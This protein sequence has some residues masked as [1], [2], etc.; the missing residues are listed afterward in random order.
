MWITSVVAD[1]RHAV[2]TIARMPVLATII[3]VSLG[4]GIGINTVVFSWMQAR[5][6]HPLP[7][8]P[9]SASFVLVE[10]RNTDNG[11]YLGTSWPEYRDL[12]ERLR[13]FPDL[14]AFRMVPLYVGESGSVDRAY[15]LLVSDNY[16]S[17]LRLQPSLGRFFRPDEVSRAGGE[18]V[19]V[20]SYGLWQARLGGATE[21]IGRPLRV[22]SRDVEIVGVA[23]R[24]FQGTVLGLNFDVWLPAT[25]APVVLRGSRELEDRSV[26]GYSAMGR[27]RPDSTRGHAQSELDAAMSELARVHPRTNAAVKG[28]ALSF[29]QSP[30]GP[31]RLLTTALAILQSVMLLLLLAVCGN[32]ATLVLARASARQREIGVRLALGASPWRIATLLLTENLLLGVLGAALGALLAVW[33]TQGLL[34]LP[35]SGLP[36]RFQTRVDGLGLAVAMILGILCGLTSGGAPALHLAR[37]DPQTALRSGAKPAGSRRLRH[38][39]MGVQAGLAVLVLVAAGLFLR[40]FLETRD[41]DPGFRRGRV[42]L[43]AYDLTGRNTDERARRAFA[44]KLLDRLHTLPSVEAAALATSVPLDIHGL[45]SRAFTVD[46]HTRTDGDSDRALA[47]TVTRGYFGVMGIPLR[48]GADFAELADVAAPPQVIVNEEFVRR[49]LDRLEPL[50][51]RLQARG[52]SYAIAGV[53]RDSLYNAFG[54]PPT[55]IVYF[56][57]RDGPTVSVEIHLRTRS[58]AATAAAHDVRRIVGEL[59]PD[60]PV[61][62]V[63]TLADHVETNLVFRRVPARM[64]AVLGPLILGLAAIGIYAVVAYSVSRRTMEIGVRVALGATTRRVVWHFVAEHLGVV[65]V[66]ALGGWLL[67]FVV[68][69]NVLGG[70]IDAPVFAGVPVLLLLVAALASWLPARH[71]A[72]VNPIDALRQE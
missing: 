64:F 26:R 1:V 12:R 52:R 57:Y 47:N 67:A 20:I 11:M 37:L 39:L 38:T 51:R 58:A 18:P 53:V 24:E 36:I 49:Y 44:G 71:A 6:L 17:A 60:L 22:N 5:L 28:E 61:F 69:L 35:L 50:G 14:L 68:V 30:R 54:E 62:N 56:S 34:A 32:T 25:L 72:R 16:F 3:V 31:Q 19:A 9:G 21:A 29:R 33:G 70:S 15:G 59:D 66:G 63:R 10:P 65:S 7:G 23:P 27:L 41:I 2:R 13:A 42:L 8:V 43:A 48:A 40:S 46:G 55:P 45:P 4:A